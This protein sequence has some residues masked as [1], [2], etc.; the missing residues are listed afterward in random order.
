LQLFLQQQSALRTEAAEVGN[1]AEQV[2]SER[3]DEALSFEIKQTLV[4]KPKKACNFA[5]L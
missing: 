1:G 2:H 5:S 4:G 3:A